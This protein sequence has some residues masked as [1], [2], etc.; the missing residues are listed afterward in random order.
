LSGFYPVSPGLSF[1]HR[2]YEMAR[3]QALLR[4]RNV[5]FLLALTSGLL[6]PFA[7]PISRHLV[8]PALAWAMTLSILEVGNDRFRNPR[9]LL[10]SALLGIVMN[11]IVI[12]SVLIGLATLIV[13]DEAIWTGFVLL[14]AVPPAIAVIPFSTIFKG[15][16]QIALFGTVGAHLSGLAIMPLI[17]LILLSNSDV[18]PLK[19]LLTAG[20]LIVLPLILSRLFIWNGWKARIEPY[21]GTMTNWCFFFV[22]YTMVGLNRNLL[23]ERIAI[24]LPIFA[25]LILSTFLLGFLIDWAGNLLRLPRNTRTSLVLLATLKNQGTAGG[26][27]ITFFSQEAALPAVLSTIVMIF[28]VLWLDF[29]KHRDW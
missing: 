18:D 21:H 7:V 10:F 29:K 12:G 19:L 2:G 23:F 13:R 5:I 3:L 8:L 9:S 15:N 4:N 1:S 25:I 6:I 14:A 17:I 28:Y 11:Y 16:M 26:I 27:A 20:Q 22:L 24:V